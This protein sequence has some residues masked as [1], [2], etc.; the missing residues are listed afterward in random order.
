MPAA[1]PVQAAVP[2]TTGQAPLPKDTLS[3]LP[4]QGQALPLSFVD[5]PHQ[6]GITPGSFSFDTDVIKTKI[7]LEDGSSDLM[8]PARPVKLKAESKLDEAFASFKHGSHQGEL[9]VEGLFKA[10]LDGSAQ[11]EAA[12]FGTEPKELSGQ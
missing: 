10:S 5:G 9:K 12:D 4:S 3:V 6:V 1:A 7:A 11:G 8:Q 2:P